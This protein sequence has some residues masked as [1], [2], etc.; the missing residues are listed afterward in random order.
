MGIKVQDKNKILSHVENNFLKI[1]DNIKENSIYEEIY[2][3][4]GDH[5]WNSLKQKLKGLKLGEKLKY[6]KY[7][8]IKDP[9]PKREKKD[10]LY[11]YLNK[12]F[13][14]EEYINDI[15]KSIDDLF[16]EKTF[17]ELCDEWDLNEDDKFK[18][19]IIIELIKQTC[20]KSLNIEININEKK[21]KS[22]DLK[23]NAI[24]DTKNNSTIN[25]NHCSNI[26]KNKIK[27]LNNIKQNN[28]NNIE[29]DTKY[30]E[31]NIIF[32]ENSINDNYLF[33]CVIEVFE[34][35]TSQ[36]DITYGIRNPIKDFE[37]ICKEF[38]IKYENECTYIDYKKAQ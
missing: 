3:E 6:I 25:E 9:P 21:E 27:E 38:E 18:L 19:K 26:K 12:V 11:S 34:Y 32:D 15:T 16:N 37:N 8:I 5:L 2:K 36:R 20:N 17:E 1:K 35:E 13:N 28:N 33:Y 24:I 31:N 22:F 7:L 23:N 14:E 30:L 29:S 10:D 4:E